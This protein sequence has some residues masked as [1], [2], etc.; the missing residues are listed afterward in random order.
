MARRRADLIFAGPQ[1]AVFVD[2]CFWHSC[3]IHATVPKANRG[4]WV[5]KLDRNV[6][7]DRET[8]RHLQSLG[9]TA[10]RFWE[11][12]ETCEVADVIERAVR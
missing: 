4:W 5:A 11:H 10:L 8:D 7:R 12:E 2:G 1:I 3:P 6:E 9:W